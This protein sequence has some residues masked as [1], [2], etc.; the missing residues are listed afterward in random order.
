MRQAIPACIR[1][2]VTLRYLA[3]GANFGVLED[4]FRVPKST[5]STLIPDVCQALWDE[6][7]NECI[8]T[9][10]VNRLKSTNLV[11]SKSFVFNIQ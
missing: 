2:Q 5:L 3:S 1:L 10:Q 9:P 4:I 6:L 7:S 11:R 8:V